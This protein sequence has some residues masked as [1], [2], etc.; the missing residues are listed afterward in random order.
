MLYIKFKIQDA[1]KFE[2][3][4]RL[5]NHMVQVRQPGFQFDDEGPE[6]DWDNMT[7]DEVDVAL[8]KLNTYLDE[9]VEP[10]KYRCK[11]LFPDYVN[12]FLKTYLRAEYENFDLENEPDV[13]PIFNYLEYSFEVDMNNLKKTNKHMGIVEFS[14]ANYPFGGMERFIIT[15]AAYDLKPVTC[16]DGYNVCD[17]SWTSQFK[18]V[19]II[20][21]KKNIFRI[22]K[23]VFIK[24]S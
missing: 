16:F 1:S 23:N 9:Q 19:S 24:D 3:F 13:V 10:E 17:F 21:S 11:A 4:K 14:T 7:K 15:L 8:K 5:Y 6:F 20:Q 18:Y 22:F 12:S 2:D